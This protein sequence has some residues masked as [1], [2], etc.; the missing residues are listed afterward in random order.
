MDAHMLIAVAANDDERDPGNKDILRQAFAAADVPAEIEV[1]EG[2]MHGWCVI[3]SAV[4]HQAQAE[5]AW[6]RMLGYTPAPKGAGLPT[7]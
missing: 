7:A 2:A 6:G 5:R 4:Y 1:Y 3:D